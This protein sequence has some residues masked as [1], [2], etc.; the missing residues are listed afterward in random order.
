M[1]EPTTFLQKQSASA[2][3]TTLDHENFR[4]AWVTT[5]VP[6][7]L[8]ATERWQALSVDADGKTKYETIEVF[9]GLLAYV[10]KFFMRGK[11]MLGFDAMAEGLKKRSEQVEE[12][13]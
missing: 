11:L 7:F 10:I 1:G 3:I 9:G 5:F 13:L 6:K 4:A 12:S 8:L 2:V